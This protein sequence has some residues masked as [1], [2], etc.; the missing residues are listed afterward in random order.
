MNAATE[1][2]FE[3]SYRSIAD[4]LDLPGRKDPQ[5]D[6]LKIVYDHLQRDDS[7]PCLMILDNADDAALFTPNTESR[8]SSNLQV[9][10]K[11][12]ESTCGPSRN[13]ALFLPKRS[14]SLIMVTTRSKTAAERLTESHHAI[15]DVSTMEPAE[16]FQMLKVK[17]VEDFNPNE[18]AQLVEALGCIPLAITQAAAYINSSAA[19]TSVKAYLENF[20]SSDENK[21]S[22]LNKD[23]GDLRRDPGVSNS[24]VITWQVTFDQI[25]KVNPSAADLLTYMSV[26]QPQKIP[27]FA[28]GGYQCSHQSSCGALGLDDVEKPTITNLGGCFNYGRFQRDLGLLMSY[29]LVSVTAKKDFCDLHP[30][31]QFCT[32]TWSATFGDWDTCRQTCVKQM[33]DL[34]LFKPCDDFSAYRM[35]CPHIRPLLGSVGERDASKW[36]SLLKDYVSYQM[37]IGNARKMQGLVQGIIDANPKLRNSKDSAADR[38][39]LLLLESMLAVGDRRAL[40]FGLKLVQTLLVNEGKMK[41]ELQINLMWTATY[42]TVLCLGSAGRFEEAAN[43][44]TQLLDAAQQACGPEHPRT[45]AIT[46]ELAEA[47]MKLG[48]E[49]LKE[50]EKQ[51]IKLNELNTARSG[52][53][54]S[55]TITGMYLLAKC[56]LEQNQFKETEKLCLRLMELDSSVLPYTSR[57]RTAC[58]S[59][60]SRCYEAQNQLEKAELTLSQAIDKL[61]EIRQGG[62]SL[63]SALLSFELGQIWDRLNRLDDVRELYS[64]IL[65]F[66]QKTR[67]EDHRVIAEIQAWLEYVERKLRKRTEDVKPKLRRH[68]KT[69]SE[70]VGRSGKLT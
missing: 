24:V 45:M 44:W 56:Y 10:P 51:I 59:S 2:S 68:K 55:N 52:V 41:T 39:Q 67:Y 32:Q 18:G 50:A 36:L 13:L 29:S 60:L 61:R 65:E 35:L 8:G 30:L 70:E 58:V 54:D 69:V 5:V 21:Q 23:N 22:L 1:T 64:E 31:V 63:G 48:P 15:R 28:L 9:E 62:L 11:E 42:A 38:L 19:F 27:M 33:A 40:E 20:R 25:R 34:F 46:L 14:Q 17:V 57:E 16:A 7:G 6:V 49:K 47:N 66:L 26:F 53:E 43:A 12:D 4:R 3:Q 37:W